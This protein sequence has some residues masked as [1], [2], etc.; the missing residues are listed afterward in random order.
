LRWSWVSSCFFIELVKFCEGSVHIRFG[1]A[2]CEEL[3]PEGGQVEVGGRAEV[4]GIVGNLLPVVPT[5]VSP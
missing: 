5:L 2:S 4:V 3:G 1:C